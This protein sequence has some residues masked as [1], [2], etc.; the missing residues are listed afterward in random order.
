MKVATA[1]PP[2]AAGVSPANAVSLPFGLVGFPEHRRMELVYLPEQLPFLWMRVYGPSPLHFIVIEP[3]SIMNDYEPELFDEDAAAIGLT[4][5]EDALVL[6]IVCVQ[7]NRPLEA[8]VNLV[9]PVIINR[10]TSVGKQVVLANHGRFSAY[11]PLLGG[12]ATSSA[13]R[14]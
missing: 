5:P 3:G 10:R 7:P 13:I 14:A 11:H 8:T 2:E 6:N 12:T 9:G 1:L 4:N